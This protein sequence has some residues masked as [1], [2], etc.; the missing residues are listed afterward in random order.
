MGT[1]KRTRQEPRRLQW[2]WAE[3]LYL[4]Q[5]KKIKPHSLEL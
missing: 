3:D 5:E 1:K 2:D 4:S